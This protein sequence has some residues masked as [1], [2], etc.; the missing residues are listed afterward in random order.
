[1]ITNPEF[2]KGF[3]VDFIEMF[4]PQDWSL[5]VAQDVA[6]VDPK[7]F[8]VYKRFYDLGWLDQYGDQCFLISGLLRRILRV[9]GIEAHCKEMI[10]NYSHSKKHWNQQIGAP[11]KITHGGFVDTHR[12]VVT[13]DHIIDWAH[14]D[15]IYRPCGAMSPRGFIADRHKLKQEQDFG[16]FGRGKWVNRTDHDGSRNINYLIRDNELNLA[17]QY[18]E[19]YKV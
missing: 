15:S 6:P 2:F 9:H 18:F 7:I 1:L 12:V 19:T 8:E 14:R 10:M 5:A 3:T 17:K 16:F 13:K 4:D 11:M